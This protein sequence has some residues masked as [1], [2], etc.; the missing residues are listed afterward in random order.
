M[1]TYRRFGPLTLLMV[2][3]LA[4]ASVTASAEVVLQVALV[5]RPEHRPIYE[6]LFRRFEESNPG[7]KVEIL[8]LPGGSARDER[9]TVLYAGDQMPD[10]WGEGGSTATF[11]VF[12]WVLDLAPFVERDRDELDIDDFLPAAW[13]NV[14]RDSQI[15]GMPWGMS[16]SAFAFNRAR[17]DEAGLSYPPVSWTDASWNYDVLLQYARQLTRR[18]ADGRVEV[19][20]FETWL[21]EDYLLTWAHL[22]G[23]DWFDAA[24]YETGIVNQV[25]INRP[26]TMAAYEEIIKL[27]HD[28][29]VMP[30]PG[31]AAWATGPVHWEPFASGQIA[32]RITSSWAYEMYFDAGLEDWGIA[33]IPQFPAGRHS[34]VANDAWHI[35]KHTNHPEEAW[36]LVKFLTSRE[37]MEFFSRGTLFGPARISALN[38]YVTDLAERLRMSPQDV[39][40]VLVGSQTHGVESQDHVFHAWSEFRSIAAEVLPRAWSKELPLATVLND[41][42]RRMQAVADSV[43]QSLGLP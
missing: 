30:G 35:W 41:A 4:G 37:A 38:P 14:Y 5:E 32:T 25:T 24:S 31:G 43:R 9:L 19:F 22:F 6:V 17:L 26:E 36:Q 1:C 3:M 11:H 8:S 40:E 33:A 23:G 29:Q 28:M 34:L 20:G 27:I 21:W 12:D 2:M 39:I 10:I 16:T 13:A 7:I 15:I 42:Q 18:T